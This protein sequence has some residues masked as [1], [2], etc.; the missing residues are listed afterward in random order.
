M[1]IANEV[2][3]SLETV[4]CRLDVK[5][6]MQSKVRKGKQKNKTEY[7]L[8]DILSSKTVRKVNLLH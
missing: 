1:F 3:L 2:I 6:C 7:V 8:K 4:K 5:Y